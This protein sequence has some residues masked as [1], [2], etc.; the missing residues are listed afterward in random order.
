MQNLTTASFLFHHLSLLPYYPADSPMVAE[1]RC[2]AYPILY[3]LAMV[4]AAD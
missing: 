2:P 1:K 4:I 3:F